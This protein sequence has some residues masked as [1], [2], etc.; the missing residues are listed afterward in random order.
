MKKVLL[1]CSHFFLFNFVSLPPHTFGTENQDLSHYHSLI[2]DRGSHLKTKLPLVILL[3]LFHC[4]PST[5][6]VLDVDHDSTK[7]LS[8]ELE[9][10][11]MMAH[12]YTLHS[13]AVNTEKS[14]KWLPVIVI[15]GMKSEKRKKENV[16]ER[17]QG[18]R[19][20]PSMTGSM[21]ESVCGE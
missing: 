2:P 18:P 15:R 21:R 8:L 1:S 13:R 17:K 4:L 20:L 10:T 9:I 3:S 14:W 7:T 16:N 6:L 12:T 19:K 11:V 5:I